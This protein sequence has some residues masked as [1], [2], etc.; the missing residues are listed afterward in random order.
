MVN[1]T[2]ALIALILGIAGI[3]VVKKILDESSKERKYVCP[4]CGYILRKGVTKCPNCKISLRWS[5]SL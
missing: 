5:G 4:E 2:Q 1:S 3:A